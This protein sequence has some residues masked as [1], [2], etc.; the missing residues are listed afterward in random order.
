M[1][2]PLHNMWLVLAV[3]NGMLATLLVVLLF[4]FCIFGGINRFFEAGNSEEKALCAAVA[5]ALFTIAVEVTFAPSVGLQ[6]IWFILGLSVAV[7][8]V[9]R[10][11]AP[12]QV[13]SATSGVA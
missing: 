1:G 8:H 2:Q 7:K 5:A 6:S 3:N 4:G 13:V 10:T 12:L 9:G 11:R